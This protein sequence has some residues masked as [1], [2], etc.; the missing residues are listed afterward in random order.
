MDESRG[1]GV[2]LLCRVDALKRRRVNI[3]IRDGIT[4]GLITRFPP[5]L[6]SSDSWSGRTKLLPRSPGME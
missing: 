2:T 5:K 6:Q 4:G 3:E 1:V